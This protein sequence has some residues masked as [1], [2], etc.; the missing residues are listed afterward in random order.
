MKRSR[1]G[2]FLARQI[3]GV[4]G[5]SG[6]YELPGLTNVRTERLTTP[7]G[8]PS[9]DYVLGTLGEGELIFLARHGQGHRLSPSE[10]NYRAN[11]YGMK[12]LGATR[13]LSVSAVG[14]MKEQ[15]VPGHLVLPDQF[16]DRTFARPR[17]FFGD[18]S[19]VVAHVG[20]S[21]P[22]CPQLHQHLKAAA[23][24]AGATAHAGGTYLCIEGPQFSTRA[25]SQLYRSWKV[26][27]D[28]FA[29]DGP[30]PKAKALVGGD[31]FAG[32]GP[33]PKAKALVDVI[34]MTA[35]PEAKLAREAELCYATLALATDYDCWHPG[36]DA[37]S[38][39][40]VVS[41]LKKN[42]AVA[43]EVIRAAVL[44]LGRLEAHGCKCDRALDF[45]VMT[46]P[47]LIPPAAREKFA[48]LLGDRYR[49]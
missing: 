34:G 18:G 40:Q 39:E 23:F 28:G 46:A 32:D 24:A 2:V 16:I 8:D 12:L 48:L 3:L 6:L 42:V 25:E 47:S 21:D 26:G 1:A 9:G 41:V 7:F 29:G 37:V 20:F 27:G 15:I 10:V 35:M 11:V 22:V 49:S 45:A 5:G 17:T 38:V 19:G 14:S 33:E 43:S 44:Q 36:H 31:G 4:I 13:L 30:E